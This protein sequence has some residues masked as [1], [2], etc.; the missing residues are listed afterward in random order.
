MARIIDLLIVSSRLEHKRDLMHILDGLGAN[1]LTVGNVEQAEE[2]LEGRRVE[3]ILCDE[4]LSD[5]IYRDVLA[6]TINREPKIQFIVVMWE[7][8]IE[9]YREAMQLGVTE[10]VHCPLQPTDVELALIHAM[11]NQR[12]VAQAMA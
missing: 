3:L 1:L 9:E 12:E 11:R 8:G 2:V 10:V 5:G 4:R 6:L 7:G